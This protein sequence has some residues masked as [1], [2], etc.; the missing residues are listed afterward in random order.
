MTSF[1]KFN[2]S[3]FD[4]EKKEKKRKIRQLGKGGGQER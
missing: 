3:F 4:K 1:F 2:I